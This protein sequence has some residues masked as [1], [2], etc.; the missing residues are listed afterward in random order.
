MPFFFFN[1]I[2]FAFVALLSIIYIFC[3]NIELFNWDYFILFFMIIIIFIYLMHNYDYYE[4]LYNEHG[5]IYI[6]FLFF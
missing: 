1:Q 4:K 3:S 2:F 6:F 5:I